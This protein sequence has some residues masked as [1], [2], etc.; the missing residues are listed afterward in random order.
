M[1]H[2]LRTLPARGDLADI[3]AYIARDNLTAADKL[4]DEFQEIFLILAQMPES[5]Q[6]SPTMGPKVRRKTHRNYVVYFQPVDGGIEILRVLHG[7]RQP[8]DLL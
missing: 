7:A 6:A 8:K 1:P 3:W 4:A 5:A 2:V